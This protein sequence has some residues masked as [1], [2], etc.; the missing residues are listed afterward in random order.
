MYSNILART[1]MRSSASRQL[2]RS[3][4]YHFSN[5]NGQNIPFNTK[6]RAG[7]AI[8]MTLYLGLGFAAPFLGAYWQFYKAG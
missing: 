3:D 4:L 8:K 5:S 1:A 7:L 2:V 6:N